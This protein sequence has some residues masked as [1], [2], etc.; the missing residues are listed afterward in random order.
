MVSWPLQ[1]NNKPIVNGWWGFLVLVMQNCNIFVWLGHHNASEYLQVNK[2]LVRIQVLQEITF[3]MQMRT[4][5]NGRLQSHFWLW[6]LRLWSVQYVNI[7][8]LSGSPVMLWPSVLPC[9]CRNVLP[10]AVWSPA[11]AAQGFLCIADAEVHTKQC[12]LHLQI[13]GDVISLGNR[14][15]SQKRAHLR[16]ISRQ[17]WGAVTQTMPKCLYS[18]RNHSPE[19]TSLPFCLPFKRQNMQDKS[20]ITSFYSAKE[21]FSSLLKEEPNYSLERSLPEAGWRVSWLPGEIRLEGEASQGA[22][23]ETVSLWAPW[24]PG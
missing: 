3:P 24:C 16:P 15:S 20:S 11:L 6:A 14:S 7:P 10:A 13:S 12:D 4:C 21:S 23:P 22:L 9:L 18:V 1:G 19:H 2:F 17:T 8:P 5:L